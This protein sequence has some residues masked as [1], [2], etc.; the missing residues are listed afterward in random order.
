MSNAPRPALELEPGNTCLHA[1]GFRAANFIDHPAELDSIFRSLFEEAPDAQLVSDKEGRILFL[2]AQTER[3]FGYSRGELIGKPLELLMPERFR[4]RHVGQRSHYAAE[5][6][7]RPMGA[8]LDLFGLRKDGTEFPIEI[9][10]SPLRGNAGTVFASA[11]RDV[12][13]RKGMEVQLQS[14][15]AFEKLVAQISSTFLSVPAAEIHGRLPQVLKT[16][17]EFMDFD[18]ACLGKLDSSQ[19]EILCSW[20]RPGV[21]PVTFQVANEFCPWLVDRVWSDGIVCVSSP[22]DLP[23]EAARDSQ[24]MRSIGEQS[25][26][27]ITLAVAKRKI[28]VISYGT[29]RHRQEWTS[30]LISRLQQIADLFANVLERKRVK[31]DLQSAYSKITELNQRLEQENLYLRQEIQLEHQHSNIVGQS[32]GIRSVLKQAEQV[33]VTDSIVLIQ[34]ETGTGKELLA[35]TIHDLSSRKSHP[36]VKINCASLPATLIESELFGREKGAYTGALS[37][38]IG[39]FELADKSTIFLDEIGELPLELQAKL[40]RVLQEGEFERLGSPKTIR[41]DVRVIAA[42]NRDLAQSVAEG[43]FREDLFYRLSVFPIHLP[44]L[45]ERREDIE[46]LVWHILQDLCKRMGKSVRSVQSSTMKAF[47]NYSWSGNI[48]ELRNVIERN[49]ILT[50]GPVFRA[51]L[52]EAPSRTAGKS[53]TRMAEVER[54]HILKVLGSTGWRIRGQ[55]GAALLLGLKPTTLESRMKKLNIQR[56]N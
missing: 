12:S 35:R 32:A 28:G 10:L 27:G 39:R 43:K 30:V 22:D 21:A 41:V 38:E 33:A 50:T 51:K 29:F 13:E 46:E 40:L 47:Q 2:N 18:R 15:L 55:S 6:S 19:L 9:S 36:M 54:E 3:L 23:Q 34:G 14:Q 26:L 5:P 16:V 48:R 24:Y 56:T 49:L 53:R 11:I 44:P 37:R 45:R 17:A 42:T 8:G 1:P 52:P 31:D 20:A 25:V 7:F 4:A